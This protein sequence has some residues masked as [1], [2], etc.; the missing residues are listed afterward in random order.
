MVERRQSIGPVVSPHGR[1]LP[2][3]LLSLRIVPFSWDACHALA[4]TEFGV[5]HKALFLGHTGERNYPAF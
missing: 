5:V 2:D 3:E 4:D 1:M